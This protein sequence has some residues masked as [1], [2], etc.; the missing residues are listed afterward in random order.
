[1]CGD[2]RCWLADVQHA[3]AR[4][5]CFSGQNARMRSVQDHLAA[6][7]IATHDLPPSAVA[8]RDGYAVAAYETAGAGYAS[9][10]SLPVAHDV[11][12]G[13]GPLRLVPGTAVRI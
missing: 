9:E 12:P 11:R 1:M 10:H 13:A 4:L 6:D 5:T 8:A 7:V 2:R 3:A